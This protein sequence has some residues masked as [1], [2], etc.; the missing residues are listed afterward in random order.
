MEGRA[1]SPVRRVGRPALHQQNS[2]RRKP[3]EKDLVIAKRGVAR[4][5]V[6]RCL[7]LTEGL[8][9]LETWRCGNE[10]ANHQRGDAACRVL[11]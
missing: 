4:S 3:A 1:S 8:V 6:W 11:R 9:A 2:G 10:I 5:E 7:A